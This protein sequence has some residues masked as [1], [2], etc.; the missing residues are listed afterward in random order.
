MDLNKVILVGRITKKPELKKTPTG[1]DV[2]SFSMATSQRFLDKDGVKQEKTEFHNVVIWGKKA[3]TFCQWM[4][5]GSLVL[6]EGRLTTRKWQDKAGV[7]HYMT[8]IVSEKESFGP[9]PAA[10]KQQ[11]TA[12]PK[13]IVQVVENNLE[14][15]VDQVMEDIPF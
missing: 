2:T 14:E 4:D 7:T 15:M 10:T 11:S 13:N 3:V 9:K 6:I 12:Q 5:K 8:E 1:Q